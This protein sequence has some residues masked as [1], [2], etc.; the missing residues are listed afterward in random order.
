[1]ES[2]IKS[3]LNSPKLFT[4]LETLI[5]VAKTEKENRA[6]FREWVT[7]GMKAE[8]ING[9]VI[10]HSPVKNRHLKAISRLFSLINTYVLVNKLGEVFQEKAMIGLTR[11]DYE[12][13]ICFW[14]KE[15]ADAFTSDQMVFP[16]ADFII[17][18]LSPSTEKVDRG[19][20]FEDYAAHGTQEYW[21]VDP[22]PAGESIEQ[23]FL[24]EEDVFQLHKTVT[25][26]GHI[27]SE[28]I[29]GLSIAVSAIFDPEDDTFL[30][31]LRDILAP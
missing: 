3:L 6:A 10:I 19:V 2:P 20:K 25:L 8:F 1:M 7:P 16:V 15:K 12:P 31:H 26:K 23:Y 11:N 17:E 4:Y 28:V 5:E 9:E 14:K 18:I 13:D 24:N 21:I 22:T 27:E 29:P 30:T